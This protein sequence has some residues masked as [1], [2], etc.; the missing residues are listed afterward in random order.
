MA[1]G[2]R[3]SDRAYR[4]LRYW[5]VGRALTKDLKHGHIALDKAG[6]AR[7]RELLFIL[8][9]GAVGFYAVPQVRVCLGTSKNFTMYWTA[10][11]D[12]GCAASYLSF[13]ASYL[14]FGMLNFYNY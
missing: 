5:W 8:S 11:S 14:S 10:A 2:T 12:L 3:D 7:R 6:I 4:V 9:Q 1:E 13:A